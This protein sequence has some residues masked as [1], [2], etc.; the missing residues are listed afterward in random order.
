MKDL[1]YIEGKNLLI[2][3]RSAEGRTERLA[4]LADD[5]VR[6]NMD[7]I[8]TAG[9]VATGAAQ[10]AT[11]TIPIVMGASAD[12]VGNG[13]VRS[14]AQPGGNIT[15][16]ST[17]RTDTGPKLLDMLRSVVPGF[18]RVAMMVNPANTAQPFSV[19]SIRSAT[20]SMRVTLLP[21]E[22]RSEEE[23]EAAFPAM[24]RAKAD[25]VILMRDGLFLRRRQQIADLAAKYRL[26][27]I[28][29]NR[30]YVDAGT[31]MSYGPS[32]AVQFRRAA[33]YVDKILKGAKPGDL[34]VEQ[35]TKFEFVL[36]LKTAKALGLTIPQSLLLLTDEVIQ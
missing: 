10:K 3:S 36:N 21:V 35:P 8:L 15:G 12:P 1:G 31:L 14:L 26:A 24:S 32:L 22:A 27:T 11:S 4:G 33:N 18:S 13:F 30:D 16:L 9:T 28:S 23:I 20:Q 6:L 2:E 25:A 5:L 29:D 17:Q 7:A 19:I 34:P